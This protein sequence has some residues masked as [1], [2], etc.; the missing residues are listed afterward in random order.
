V[1]VKF[2]STNWESKHINIGLFNAHDTS[3]TAMVVKLKQILDKFSF[4]K[5]LAYIKNRGSNLQTCA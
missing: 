1:V 3:G 4:T 2:L 5:K